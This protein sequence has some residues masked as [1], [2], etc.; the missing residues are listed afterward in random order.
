[1]TASNDNHP[2]TQNSKPKID[3]VFA[4][5][6]QGK[7]LRHSD[8]WNAADKFVQARLL[9]NLLATEQPRSTEEEKQIATLYERQAWEYLKQSRECLIEAMREEKEEDE[10][11]E[12]L[13]LADLTDSQAEARLHTF[14]SL[15]SRKMES[16]SVVDNGAEENEPSLEERLQN[17]NASLPSGF[18]TSEERMSDINQGLNKL[19][20]SLYTQKAPFARFLEDEIAKDEGQQ[21]E[22]IIAQA[23]DE[24]HFEQNFAVASDNTSKPSSSHDDDED[25]GDS[26]SDQE[27]EEDARLEDDVLA[28][29]KIR[30]RA[31][32][33][34]VKLAELV[35][36]LDEARVLRKAEDGDDLLDDDS[37]TDNIAKPDSTAHLTSA[38]KKLKG[39]QSDLKRAMTY[40]L[41]DLS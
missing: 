7:E 19:G 15:F 18:K 11:E 2:S 26:G 25:D 27:D 31:E 22:D 20:L 1:M 6:Q 8:P 33:A 30:R 17:L 36:L 23:K 13:H 14:S 24:V 34:R 39:A 29:K 9:L 5:I 41:E 37:S 38:K 32:K 40:W 21:V 35:V 16:A 10:K 28:M 4:L 3:D 12:K